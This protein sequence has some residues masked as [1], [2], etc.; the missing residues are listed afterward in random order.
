MIWSY[1]IIVSVMHVLSTPR[2][3]REWPEWSE[4]TVH[5]DT[6]VY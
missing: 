6:V 1:I 2:F 5:F 3:D 4:D